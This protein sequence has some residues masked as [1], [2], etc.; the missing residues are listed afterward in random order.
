MTGVIVVGLAVALVGYAYV[1][2]PGLLGLAGRL[3]RPASLPES[4]D[5]WP[6]ITILLPA[7]NEERVIATA[8]TRIL[9]ADYPAE[10]RHVLVISDASSD[11]TDDVVRG[12]AERGVALV[13][14]PR[15]GGKTAAENAAW[16]YLRGTI[17]VST[18]ASVRLHPQSL[19]PLI[20]AFRDPRVGVAS[21]RDVSI[22]REGDA[23]VGESGYVGYEMWVRGL[24]TAAGGIVGASGCYYASLV[25]L[26][27]EVVP[28][29]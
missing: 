28:E 2:Y 17:V 25:S 20:A 9:E 22:G 1:V 14:M 27:R 5:D 16:N 15:R 4:G 11:G 18:D 8:I 13:R 21:G 29:A 3:A 23:N 10:R 24:E 12:F 6:E 19:K 26:Y 7:Y